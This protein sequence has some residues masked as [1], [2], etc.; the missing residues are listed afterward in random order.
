MKLRQLG[1]FSVTFV[2]V[3]RLVVFFVTIVVV[4]TIVTYTRLCTFLLISKRVVV[5]LVT[6]H[7]IQNDEYIIRS[8]CHT[9]ARA[10]RRE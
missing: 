5:T 3:A 1:S 6:A 2:V 10:H 9:P 8:D 7:I 4:P